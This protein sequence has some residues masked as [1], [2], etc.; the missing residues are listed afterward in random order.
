MRFR[1]YVLRLENASIQT[2]NTL[3]MCALLRSTIISGY[4]SSLARL[5]VARAGGTQ[6][7][8][9]VV[10]VTYMGISTKAMRRG[11]IP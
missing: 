10:L 11:R 4:R 2:E 1:L 5:Y 9:Y 3:D 6:Q 8:G 7:R